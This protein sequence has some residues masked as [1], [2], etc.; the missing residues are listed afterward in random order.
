MSSRTDNQQSAVAIPLDLA[1]RAS[2]G[3]E[4]LL[5]WDGS[6]GGLRVVVDDSRTG[7]SF[8]LSIS[9]GR[10]ALDAF[11]HPY[12]YAAERKIEVP[13]ASSAPRRR[14]VACGL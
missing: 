6:E 12:A 11:Y 4:V 1:R 8:E 13:R 10:T 9:D 2:D 7:D 3:L 14:R 5:L